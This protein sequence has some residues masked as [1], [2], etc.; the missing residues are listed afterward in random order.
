METDLRALAESCGIPFIGD[1][2]HSTW[3]ENVE[4]VAKYNDRIQ[5]I[6]LSDALRNRPLDPNEYHQHLPL[7]YGDYRVLEFLELLE[8]I[9]YAHFIVLEYHPEYDDLLRSD[10]A[11]VDSW[12]HGDRTMLLAIMEARRKELRPVDAIRLTGWSAATRHHR[13]GDTPDSGQKAWPSRP[14]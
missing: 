10:A 5:V 6:H 7:G 9:G 12:F 13:S 8:R 11:A 4:E 3:E 14:E 2:T 1:F